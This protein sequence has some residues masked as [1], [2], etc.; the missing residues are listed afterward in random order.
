MHHSFPMFPR[1]PTNAR[2]RDDP[3]VRFEFNEIK[4]ALEFDRN[5]AAN[6]G[7]KA[8]IQTPGN[9]KR[10]NIIV[11]IAFFSQ[12]SGNGIASYYL[13]KVLKDIGIPN[14]T[15]QVSQFVA[16]RYSEGLI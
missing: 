15:T 11:A 5:V 14:P 12:W 7:W 3:L 13:N 6:V 10:M 9:R 8:L 4:A 2:H 1:F 16:G